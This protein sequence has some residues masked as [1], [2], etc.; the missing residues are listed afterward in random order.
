MDDVLEK[1]ERCAAASLQMAGDNAVRFEE[2]KTEAILSSRRRKQK[3]RQ[4]EI[5][6]GASHGVRFSPEAT[7]WLGFW[8][9]S[10][11]SL[12]E[13]RRRR[14]GETRQAEARLRRIASWPRPSC[15]VTRPSGSAGHREMVVPGAS[16]GTV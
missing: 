7:R 3:R 12:A 6:V 1:L 13:N 15:P 2:S 8:L 5:R 10:I 4:R 9:D 14:I 16:P 11:L